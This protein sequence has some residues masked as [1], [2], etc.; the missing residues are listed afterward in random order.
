MWRSY[1]EVQSQQLHHTKGYALEIWKRSRGI[2]QK[3]NQKISARASPTGKKSLSRKI[4][5]ASEIDRQYL[6]TNDEGG[7][8]KK[9]TGHAGIGGNSPK[10]KR[11]WGKTA[12]KRVREIAEAIKTKLSVSKAIKGKFS[13]GGKYVK[14][15]RSSTEGKFFQTDSWPS[16]LKKSAQINSQ[17]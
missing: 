2:S 16:R 10:R 13:E 8:I 17:I 14:R 4:Y 3:P 15:N 7:I 6:N 5:G 12:K 1:W 9:K 11:R